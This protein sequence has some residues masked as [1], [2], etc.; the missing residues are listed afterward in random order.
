MFFHLKRNKRFEE[1]LSKFYSSQIILAFEYLHYNGIVHRDLKPENVLIGAD[2]YVLLCDFGFCK[3]IDQ[4]RTYT[5]CGTPD[6]LAP[7][8]ILNKGKLP[9][10]I[11]CVVQNITIGI[12]CQNKDMVFMW[13]GGHLEF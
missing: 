4:N 1:P 3:K 8:I 2:G 9:Y 6:Y 11:M 10:C 12:L 5:L 13:I 7:E